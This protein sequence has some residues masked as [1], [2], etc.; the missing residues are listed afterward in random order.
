MTID[1]KVPTYT[2][3]VSSKFIGGHAESCSQI[4]RWIKV[5]NLYVD[6]LDFFTDK[7]KFQWAVRDGH[8]EVIF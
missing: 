6:V 8:S 4:V 7:K 5:A 2:L 3:H 1:V